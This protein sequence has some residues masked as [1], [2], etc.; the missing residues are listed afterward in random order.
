MSRIFHPDAAREIEAV[1]AGIAK[2]PDE[3]E[4]LVLGD[5]ALVRAPH[6]H[7]QRHDEANASAIGDAERLDR[8]LDSLIHA[9][10]LVLAKIAGAHGDQAQ[11][12]VDPRCSRALRTARIRNETA[13]DRPRSALDAR[14]DLFRVFQV[15]NHARMGESSNFD[16]LEPCLGKAIDQRHFRVCID[17]TRE[18][19]QAISRPH[20]CHRHLLW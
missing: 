19:L 17:R 13:V 3:R 16:Y 5:A 11:H 20:L 4:H 10:V 2:A 18:T 15:W 1:H 14:A 12:L 9:H 7:P 6:R 8:L